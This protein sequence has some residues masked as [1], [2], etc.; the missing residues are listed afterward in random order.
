MSVPTSSSTAPSSSRGPTPPLDASSRRAGSPSSDTV[1]SD[2]RPATPLNIDLGDYDPILEREKDFCTNF[3]CCGLTLPDMHALLD[4][5]EESHVVIIDADGRPVYPAP[6]SPT[7]A[8]S[9][10]SSPQPHNSPYARYMPHLAGYS[11]SNRAPVASI[12]IDYPKPCPPATPSAYNV[13]TSPYF[14]IPEPGL[15]LD[16]GFPDL[17]DPYDPFGFEAHS[18]LAPAIEVDPPSPTAPPSPALSSAP[19][20]FDSL[21]SSTMSSPVTSAFSTPSPKLGEAACL[22]P[23]ALSPQ[24]S[25]P[26]CMPPGMLE[27]PQ[28]LGSNTVPLQSRSLS[29]EPYSIP[30]SISRRQPYYR[31]ED[32]SSPSPTPSAFRAYYPPPAPAPAGSHAGRLKAK[33]LDQPAQ[34]IKISGRRRDRDREKQYRCPNP[35]CTKRYLNPNGLKYH[36]EKGTCTDQGPRPYVR[37]NAGGQAAAPAPVAA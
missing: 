12:V 20:I 29:P 27:N 28:P 17:A 2:S 33:L 21:T 26:A 7:P 3:S 10:Q 11:S 32:Q 9:S 31:A 30:P 25:G 16:L 18:S 15:G 6:P 22:S 4:H 34:A 37:K 36:V 14:D 19:S 1:S 24:P 5:F 13:P 8:H 35:N 23:V